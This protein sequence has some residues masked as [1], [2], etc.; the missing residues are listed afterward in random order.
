VNAVGGWTPE[1][2][3]A[4]RA[5]GRCWAIARE[6]IARPP[7]ATLEGLALTALAAAILAERDLTDR[8]PTA[9]AAVGLTRAVFAFT[10]TPL[11]SGFSGFGDAPDFKERED[12]LHRGSCT[13]PSWAMAGAEDRPCA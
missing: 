10:G 4:H 7:D 13:I 3:A 12:A 9:I 11:P 1:H 2:E 8:D 6:V 5:Q